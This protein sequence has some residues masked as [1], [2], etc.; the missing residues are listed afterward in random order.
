MLDI[1]THTFVCSVSFGTDAK[2]KE[3]D[4]AKLVSR[5]SAGCIAAMDALNPPTFVLGNQPWSGMKLVVRW[6][7]LRSKETTPS[8]GLYHHS[9]PY[10]LLNCK[11]LLIGTAAYSWLRCTVGHFSDTIGFFDLCYIMASHKLRAIPASPYTRP[12]ANTVALRGEG[13]G[14]F[15]TTA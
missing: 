6:D 5:A 13:L 11:W 4:M 9:P 7:R 8:I 3:H 2:G 14:T 1:F 12:H 10:M 15:L